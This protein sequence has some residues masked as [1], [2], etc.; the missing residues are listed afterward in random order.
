MNVT[1]QTLKHLRADAQ[2]TLERATRQWTLLRGRAYR[3]MREMVS[4]TRSRGVQWTRWMRL[5]TTRPL[6]LNR[7]RTR[8][9]DAVGVASAQRVE[10]MSQQLMRLAKRVDSLSKKN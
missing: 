7:W 9:I 3:T 6:A 4:D 1:A 10:R 5:L 8:L 2:T